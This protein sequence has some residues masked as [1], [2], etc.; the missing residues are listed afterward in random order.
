MIGITTAHLQE[1]LDRLRGG[2]ERARQDLLTH[3][4]QRLRLLIRRAF[5]HFPTVRR[6]VEEDDVLQ[7]VLLRLDRALKNLQFLTALDFLKLASTNIRREMIDLARWV[8]GPRSLPAHHIT[9]TPGSDLEPPPA[10]AGPPEELLA[11]SELHTR[12]GELPDQEREMFDLLWYQGM[13]Q[14]EAAE[15][16]GISLTV[17]R[18]RWQLARLHLLDALGGEL[19]L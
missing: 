19:P 6:W 11:W 10:L 16:L 13:S 9:P 7:Q 2:D 3:A 15:L 17:V 12:I 4:Q 5:R 1:C 18:R 8:A 14:E